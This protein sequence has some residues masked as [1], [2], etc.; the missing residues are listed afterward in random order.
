M[1]IGLITNGFTSW[2]GGIDFI[3]H[4]ATSVSLVN[5]ER[6][7]SI[8]ILPGNDFRFFLRKY[9][10]PLKQCLKQLLQGVSPKWQLWRGFDE[11]YLKKNFS[12]LSSDCILLFSGSSLKSQLNAAVLCKPG[13]IL[14]C[15]VPPPDN[16]SLPWIGYIYDFQHCYLTDFFTQ[17]E[18]KVRNNSFL[19]MLHRANHIIVN[20]REVIS[21]AEKFFGSF[22][23]KLHALP[24][25]PCPQISWLESTLDVRDKYKIKK[26]YF[27]VCNQFWKHKDH[28]TAF[29]GFA[30]FISQGGDALLVCTGATHDSRFPD[31]F[32]ELNK[33]ILDLGMQDLIKILGHIPKNDQISLVKFTLA[34]VQSTLF[35]GGP[36]GGAAYDAIALG[37]PVIASNIPVNLEINCG[38]VSFFTASNHNQLAVALQK[39]GTKLKARPSNEKLLE[40][41]ITR[42]R[43]CGEF[44]LH[45]G[46][47]AITDFNI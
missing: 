45:I 20:A 40:D 31:Y 16:Y 14:P 3:H 12:D 7:E 43:L 33:L 28:V 21:D 24:F 4:I 46:S 5:K 18:I 11:D 44:I 25:S 19:V 1:K 38:D 27:M 22:P 8:L 47:Q 37:I 23:A 32:D 26:P 10:S 34:I 17:S 41:G 29:R 13:V 30:E 9:L 39:R 36:G 15:I 6:K 2:G 42:K 35:E